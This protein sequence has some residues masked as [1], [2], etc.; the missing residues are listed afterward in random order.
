MSDPIITVDRVA[1]VSVDAIDNGRVLSVPV[2]SGEHTVVLASRGGSTPTHTVT[3]VPA[4]QSTATLRCDR[5]NEVVSRV[6]FADHAADAAAD[7]A[8]LSSC[9]TQ[10]FAHDVEKACLGKSV[11]DVMIPSSGCAD[12]VV[13]DYMCAIPHVSLA[14]M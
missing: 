8:T 10:L 2:G 14:Q 4:G 11:C 3:V 12:A 6:V 1:V 5:P 9:A 13:V 7:H